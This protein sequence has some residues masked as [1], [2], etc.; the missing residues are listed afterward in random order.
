MLAGG[1]N[2]ITSAPNYNGFDEIQ[3]R[4]RVEFEFIFVSLLN[5]NLMEKRRLVIIHDLTM[6]NAVAQLLTF[7]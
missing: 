5:F 2:K 7:R 6:V 3:E 1:V 4:A